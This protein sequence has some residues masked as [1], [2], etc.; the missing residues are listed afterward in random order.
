MRTFLHQTQGPYIRGDQLS[1]IEIVAF[2][3]LDW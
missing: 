1:M 3:M 2:S